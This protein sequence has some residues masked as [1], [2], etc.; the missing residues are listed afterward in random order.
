MGS[1]HT[2]FPGQHLNIRYLFL[3]QLPANIML[4]NKLGILALLFG[5]AKFGQ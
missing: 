1:S 2:N 3:F 5:E 4:A